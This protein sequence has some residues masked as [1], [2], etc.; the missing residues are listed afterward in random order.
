MKIGIS[1]KKAREEKG[2]NLDDIQ[3]R[4]KIRKKYLKALEEENYEI[5]PGEA[6][7]KVFIKS[8]ARQVDLEYNKLL[9]A[10][11][12]YLENKKREEEEDDL[13]E[14]NN[15]KKRTPQNNIFNIIIILIISLVIIFI[16]YNIFILNNSP[17]ELKVKQDSAPEEIVNITENVAEEEKVDN[18]EE[19]F[20]IDENINNKNEDEKNMKEKVIEEAVKLHEII[21]LASEKSWLKVVVDGEDSFLGF[22]NAGE[23]IEYK[24][25]DTISL[26]IGN[27]AAIKLKNNDNV[28]GPW[29]EQGEVI[30]KDINLSEGGFK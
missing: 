24:V 8:Y 1:L 26:K 6:Y 21:I 3:K 22:I 2:L 4:T 12:E 10:Y 17:K 14:D 27:A 19:E 30:Q 11:N 20:F 7:V 25:E 18:I 29:G 28:I 16:V 13:N 15:I 9:N 23:S 5:I